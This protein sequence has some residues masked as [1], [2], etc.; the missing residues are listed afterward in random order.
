MSDN[1]SPVDPK[2]QPK[3]SLDR[4]MPYVDRTK[5]LNAP[6]GTRSGGELQPQAVEAFSPPPADAVLRIGS[7]VGPYEV[8]EKLGQ[9]GMG[10]VYKARHAKLKK[11][12]AIKVLSPKLIGDTD[13]I[14]RFE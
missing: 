10:A 4:T 11:L 1:D 14:A 5:P 6:D 9:G 8:I 13:A 12:V 7:T 3:A 2:E